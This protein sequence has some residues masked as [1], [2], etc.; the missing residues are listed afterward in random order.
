[1]TS[2]NDMDPTE[3]LACGAKVQQSSTAVTGTLNV[4]LLEK[5]NPKF[6]PSQRKKK[7]K[8]KNESYVS[9]KGFILTIIKRIPCSRTTRGPPS[10]I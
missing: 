9:N 1:M 2:K 8:K 6:Y 4:S 3:Q 7:E 10:C 5:K